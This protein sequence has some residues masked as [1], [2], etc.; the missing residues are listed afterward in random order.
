MSEWIPALI[1]GAY[2]L[3]SVPFGYFI[4]RLI[5]GMDIRAL[6]SGNIGATNVVRAMGKRW[7]LFV[8]ALDV[9]KGVVPALAGLRMGGPAVACCAGLAA[10]A[11]HNWPYFLGFRGGKGVAT[12][13]G[14]FLAVFPLG[15]AA[16]LAAWGISLKLWRYVSLSSIIGGVVLLAAALALQGKPFGAGLPVTVLAG[17]AAVLGVVRHRANIARLL[18]GTEP[19]IGGS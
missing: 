11:G 19:R 1:F 5:R 16:A 17:I 9:A 8:F 18:N 4:P 2:F 3:G 14:V 15:L 10:V 12:S 13:C 6:G 7:G